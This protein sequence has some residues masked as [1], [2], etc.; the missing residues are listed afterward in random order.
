MMLLRSPTQT[1]S[2]PL[3]RK[4]KA[5][6]QPD[7]NERL[8]KR[9]SLLNLEQNGQKLYIPVENAQRTDPSS[10]TY[11]PTPSP[12]PSRS[13]PARQQPSAQDEEWMQLDDTKHKVYI[14]NI[15]DELSSESEAES[16]KDK[17][18]FLPDIERHL[19]ANRIPPHVV[20]G[21][22]DLSDKQLVLYQVPSSISVPEEQDSVRK[23]IIEA[24]E[25]MR[26]RQRAERE[27]MQVQ[28]RSDMA[29][30][31]FMNDTAEGYGRQEEDPDAMEL[32]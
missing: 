31:V 22:V 19:R 21:P 4:R 24:R 26:E 14:Y 12:P 18:V 29:S 1:Q 8:S 25:R 20:L 30:G 11:S 15:D 17:V 16:D 13:R 32:D 28:A 10:T 9:L 7:N 23:A 6:T 5:D 27:G 2:N 3:R